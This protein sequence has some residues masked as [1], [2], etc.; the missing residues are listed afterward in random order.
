LETGTVRVNMGLM[1]QPLTIQ[2]NFSL[3]C[4]KTPMQKN[5]QNGFTLIELLIV[6]AIVGVLAG[7]AY[8]S[9]Q[10]SMTKSR[11]AD[12]KA[13]LLELSVF[14]ER[15]Y[16]TT[17]CYNPGVDKICGTTDDT[18]APVLAP[19]LRTDGTVVTP[20]S[21]KA[22]YDLSLS[23]IT[24]SAFT[25]QA[26]PKSTAPDSVCG[27]LTLTYTGVKGEGG[28]GAVADCW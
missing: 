22:N 28:S 7:I 4:R 19:Y 1:E 26:A 17:G 23:I 13:A 20:K 21:G 8:P 24:A 14:M 9:Y 11:R 27:A 3:A 15:L 12:A 6:V 25:L 10:D 18:T 2:K 16:T 5:T